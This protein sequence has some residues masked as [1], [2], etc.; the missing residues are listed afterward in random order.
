MVLDDQVNWIGSVNDASAN[1]A[2]DAIRRGTVENNE[3][4]VPS[5]DRADPT[6]LK[7]MQGGNSDHR[8]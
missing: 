4:M 1:D 7:V 5:E 8:D 3:R 6:K 2:V